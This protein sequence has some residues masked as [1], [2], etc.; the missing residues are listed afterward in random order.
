MT[1][2]T[3]LKQQTLGGIWMK[4][5]DIG[6]SLNG[7]CSLQFI[8]FNR[9][10]PL[11]S[12][13]IL[14]YPGTPIFGNT[15]MFTMILEEMSLEYQASLH[16]PSVDHNKYDLYKHPPQKIDKERENLAFEKDKLIFQTSI[17]WRLRLMFVGSFHILLTRSAGCVAKQI[18][19]SG[20]HDPSGRED[21]RREDQAEGTMD[22][23]QSLVGRAGG[24]TS[25]CFDSLMT[26]P[27][28]PK[29]WTR[30]WSL[31]FR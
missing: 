20:R 5:M 28:N 30:W 1:P 9:G 7:G 3:Y 2:T 21:W 4:G 11:F 12:P 19:W 10:F 27:M 6:V 23:G 17:F 25:S 8:H 16:L 22:Y 13:S 26:I 18:H 29:L 24:V 31:R 14:G 15:H